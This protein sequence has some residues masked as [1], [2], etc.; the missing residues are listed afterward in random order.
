MTNNDIQN[1]YM[2]VSAVTKIYLGEDVVWPTIPP[3][4][5]YSAMPLTFEIISGGTISWKTNDKTYMFN[6]YPRTIEY[7]KDGGNTW[8]NI[9]SAS[10]SGAPSIPV[11][12]GDIIQFRGNNVNYGGTYGG[13]YSHFLGD[14]SVKFNIYGNLYSLVNKTN[15]TSITSFGAKYVFNDLFKD[16]SGLISAK[17]L[18]LPA[19]RLSTGTYLHLFA[20]CSSLVEGPE[21][22]ATV[23]GGSCYGRMFYECSKLTTA[24]ELPATTLAEDCYQEMF[25]GCSNLRTAPELPA[26]TLTT[27]CYAGMFKECT[28]LS[29]VKCLATNITALACT[30]EWLFDARSTGR[31]VKHPDMTSWTRNEDGIPEGW[32]VEDADI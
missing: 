1:A 27:G 13:E 10:G 6:V 4:P 28:R 18:M 32:T 22:P 21:L 14:A 3:E 31:F 15:Y 9:T 17:N 29:Y 30:T 26:P 16:N 7:S 24:P 11:V 20:N 8:T 25:Y 2:G 19:N 5:V 12:A 23:L